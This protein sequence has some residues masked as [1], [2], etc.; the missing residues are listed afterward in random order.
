MKIIRCSVCGKRKIHAKGLCRKCYMKQYRENNREKA[1]EYAKQYRENNR[2]KCNEDN[3]QYRIS[4]GGQSMSENTEC[5]SYL[6]C[7]V[8]EQVL[9]KVF[10]NVKQMPYGNK[11]FDFFCN[12]GKKIDVKASVLHTNGESLGQ[13]RF[14]IK[15]N[16]IADYFLCLAFDNRE[17]LNPLHIWLIPSKDINYLINAAISKSTIHKWDKYKLDINKVISCCDTLKR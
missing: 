4:N 1:N 10:K 3:K 2:E 6:G 11:G 8:A 9:S 12:K 13:W 5:A 15:Q 14:K 17:D 16:I 7:H